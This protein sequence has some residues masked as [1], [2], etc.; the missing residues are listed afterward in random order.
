MWFMSDLTREELIDILEGAIQGQLRSMRKLRKKPHGQEKKGGAAKKSNISIIEDILHA[1]GGPLHINE[2]IKRAK[3]S[4][5][6]ELRRESIV[7]ALTK[8][9][10]DRQTFCRVGRNVFS[11]IGKEGDGRGERV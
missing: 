9:V 1:A 5:G 3:K 7:S 2:I 10:L 6:R 11:L 4:Y 8:K